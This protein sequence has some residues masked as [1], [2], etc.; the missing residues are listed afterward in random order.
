MTR[1]HRILLSAMVL[2]W[3]PVLAASAGGAGNLPGTE[4]GPALLVC[5]D[6]P[7]GTDMYAL[8]ATAQC[9]FVGEKGAGVAY[10]KCDLMQGESIS[11]SFEFE[12]DGIT[13]NVC[14]LLDDGVGNGF[15]V[16]TYS[17]P[18]QLLTDYD[19]SN[20]PPLAVYTCRPGSSG[21][22]AQCDGG[23]CFTSSETNQFPG[24]PE[25]LLD[26]E[27]ICSCPITVPR[28]TLTGRERD[29]GF[30][31]TGPWEIDGVSCA[32]G[33]GDSRCCSRIF[34]KQNCS[35]DSSPSTGATIF[36]GAPPGVGTALS[37]LLDGFPP[38]FNMCSFR[39]R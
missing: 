33:D 1:I 37:V 17:T 2:V 24:F 22:Y 25:P 32:P 38:D 3:L 6:E 31:I 5:P 30:Q 7:G 28:R 19:G 12:S 18:E 8:C 35:A 34:A 26:G 20:G 10:C 14:D 36:V 23:F 13:N 11:E 29:L 39:R 15:T 4:N 21:P 16:S 9:F 27:I